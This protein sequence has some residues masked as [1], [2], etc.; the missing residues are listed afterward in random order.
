M[1]CAA[2]RARTAAV[3]VSSARCAVTGGGMSVE[4]QITAGQTDERTGDRPFFLFMA[5]LLLATAVVGFAPSSLAILS[6]EDPSPPILVH[7]H[8]ALMLSWLLLLVAQASLRLTGRME[9]HRQLG[10][11]AFVLVPAIVIVMILASYGRLAAAADPGPIPPIRYN[12]LLLQL[13]SIL[14]FPLF[15]IWALSAR[16]SSPATHK[17]FMIVA[18]V[19]VLDAALARTG[20]LPGPGSRHESFESM[21]IVQ[22]LLLMPLVA[23]DLVSTRRVHRA[24]IIGISV[25]AFFAVVLNL[26]WG[27]EW[28]HE[29]AAILA[30]YIL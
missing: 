11:I 24:T 19:V 1:K 10:T 23:H 5:V 15:V 27:S 2:V 29:T 8:A 22:F 17:R 20:W 26:L 13:R 12:I 21:S 28:W 9:F 7:I 25:F 18:T 3:M 14:L 30:A 4:A 6:R 16:R